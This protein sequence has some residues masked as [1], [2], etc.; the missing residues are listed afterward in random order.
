[1]LEKILAEDSNA[2]D[3]LMEVAPFIIIGVIWIL[4]AVAKA[5]QAGAKRKPQVEQ[6]KIK[7]ARKSKGG[8]HDFI[9]IVKQ[10]YAAAMEQATK[11]AESRPTPP[12][13]KQRPGQKPPAP[14]Y[15]PSYKASGRPAKKTGRPLLIMEKDIEGRPQPGSVKPIYQQPAP[16]ETPE[17]IT[18]AE[19][20][21]LSYDKTQPVAEDN[22][23]FVLARQYGS[24]EDLRKA[25]LHYEILGK[26]IALREEHF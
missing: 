14:A 5:V 8:L 25:I 26:P 10:R 15:R 17:Q 2:M 1:V 11:A 13:P 22:M 19:P 3:K 9:M 21:M 7:L 6:E 16:V 18:P 12:K 4:G 20:S 23:L 24:A